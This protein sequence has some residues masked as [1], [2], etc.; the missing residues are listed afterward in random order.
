MQP[1]EKVNVSFLIFAIIV[2]SAVGF[3][4]GRNDAL[5]EGHREGRD[6]GYESGYED[7]RQAEKN[8]RIPSHATGIR[9]LVWTPDDERVEL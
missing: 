7:G 6:E 8:S 2:A 1:T 9:Y 3:A 4:I 5:R